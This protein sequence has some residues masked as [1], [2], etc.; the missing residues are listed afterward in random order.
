[1]GLFPAKGSWMLIEGTPEERGARSPEQPAGAGSA[2]LQGLS[3]HWVGLRRHSL[4]ASGSRAERMREM[5]G[6]LL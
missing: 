6:N 4:Q 1:M 5:K 2:G 3:A